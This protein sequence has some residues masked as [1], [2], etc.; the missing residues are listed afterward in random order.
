LKSAVEFYNEFIKHFYAD[1]TEESLSILKY[2]AEHGNTI[3]YQ[4]KTGGHLPISVERPALNYKFA[5]AIQTIKQE[6]TEQTDVI[7]GLDDDHLISTSDDIQ[8]DTQNDVIDFDVVRWQI[9]L[10]FFH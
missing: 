1:K 2:L 8:L 7:V 4:W 3:V 6:E 5:Q 10:Y 9:R